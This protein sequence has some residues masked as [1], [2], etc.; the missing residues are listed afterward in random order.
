MFLGE[1]I[2]FWFRGDVIVEIRNIITINNL[3]TVG[4]T[5]I[6]LEVYLIDLLVKHNS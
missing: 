3:R 1:V 6:G 4:V 2:D 5:A